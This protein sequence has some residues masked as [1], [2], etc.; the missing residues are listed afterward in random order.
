MNELECQRTGNHAKQAFCGNLVFLQRLTLRVMPAE[1]S[2]K[3][4]GLAT[5]LFIASDQTRIENLSSITLT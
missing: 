3:L 5:H 4:G 1:D 2:L